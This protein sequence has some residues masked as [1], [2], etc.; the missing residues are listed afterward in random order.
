MSRAK[1]K[2]NIT[3]RVDEDLKKEADELFKNLGLNTSVVLNSFLTQCVRQQEIPYKPSMNTFEPSDELK[4]ALK[5]T[6]EIEK[7]PEKYKG[8]H[9]VDAFIKDLLN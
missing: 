6:E 3:F 5:E 7:H 1:K 8:Y 9:D 4:A 2:T